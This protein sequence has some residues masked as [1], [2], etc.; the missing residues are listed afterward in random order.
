MALS[1]LPPSHL[2]FEVITE[3]SLK[4]VQQAPAIN[5]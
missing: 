4:I 1:I 3:T 2:N 5:V